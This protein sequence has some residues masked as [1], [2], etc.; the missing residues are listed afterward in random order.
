MDDLTNPHPT[1][2]DP[3][4]PDQ[5]WSA[6]PT[7]PADRGWGAPPTMPAKPVAW[8]SASPTSW[9]PAPVLPAAAPATAATA[10]AARPQA[11]RTVALVLA[12][13]LAAATLASAG[14]AALVLNLRPVTAPAAATS[15]SSPASS[16]S[17]TLAGLDSSSA[18]VAVAKSASPAVV[19]ITTASSQGGGLG[20]QATGIGSGFLYDANGWILTNYH[21]VEGAGTLTVSLNDGRELTGR[22][23]STDEAHDLAVV[24]IDGTGF[25]TIPIGSSANLQVGQLVIAIGS[26]L[27]QFTD[28]VTSGIL[29]ATGRS[30]TVV[31]QST[32]QRRTI[33]DLLQTDAAINE[34][35]SGG[36]LLDAQG[37]VIGIDSATAATAQGIGFAIPIDTAATIMASA[38]TH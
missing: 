31:D 9:T 8:P 17:A 29:S 19:T 18:I 38:M 7:S 24:K 3:P 2:D 16:G 23:A 28:S 35:N 6:P 15:A 10:P 14:T 34:G 1:T 36:P 25:P 12:G 32:R 30:I 5:G 21:V 33:T 22:V 26:P 37:R 13:S 4:R 27:G 20:G 11:R